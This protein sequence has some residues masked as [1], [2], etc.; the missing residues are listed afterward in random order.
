MTFWAPVVVKFMQWR[1][2]SRLNQPKMSRYSVCTVI[3]HN[4]LRYSLAYLGP[5]FRV[6]YDIL[7]T[8]GCLFDA[9]EIFI[10]F[11]SEL[12]NQNM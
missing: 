7:G 3:Q 6:K 12:I 8:D 9:L 10:Q 5:I 4:I 2:A 1:Y 11:E